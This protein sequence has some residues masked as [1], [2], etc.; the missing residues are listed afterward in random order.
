MSR[1]N[2]II[3]ERTQRRRIA[4]EAAAARALAALRPKGIDIRVFGSLARGDFRVHSDV[5]FL[6]YGPID[7]HIRSAVESG[8]AAAIGDSELPYDILYLDDMTPEQA[9][10]FQNG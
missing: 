4:A 6:V 3:A 8:V 2:I 7:S 10:A 9:A 1:F 5:D